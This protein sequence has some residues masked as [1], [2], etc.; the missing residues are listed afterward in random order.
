MLF[1]DLRAF[2]RLAEHKL[3]YDVVFLLNRYF[4]AMGTA[5]ESAG[6]QLDKFIGTA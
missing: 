6:G 4:R 3:P 5:V 2:T 1:A